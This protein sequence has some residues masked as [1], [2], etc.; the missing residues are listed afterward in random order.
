[1]NWIQILT[2]RR[3]VCDIS[4]FTFQTLLWNEVKTWWYLGWNKCILHSKDIDTFNYMNYAP[5]YS[6]VELLDLTDLTIFG[7]ESSR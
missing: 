6:H 3:H 7:D 1:M 2:S 5:K 4:D